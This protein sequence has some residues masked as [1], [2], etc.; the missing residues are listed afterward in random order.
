MPD[1]HQ[2]TLD[3][4]YLQ[5]EGTILLSGIQAL[6]RIP[7]DQHRADKRNGLDTATFISGYRGSPLGGLDITLERSSRVLEE[8]QVV[9]VPGVNE[10]LGATAVFGSQ[11][12]NLLPK[13]KHDGVLGMWYGKGPG[14]D[15]SGDAFRHANFTG[16]GHYGGVLALAGDD[17]VAKSSTIPSQSEVGLYDLHMPTLYPGSIQE[18]LD[19]GR[20]GFELSRYCGS[21]VGFKIV[22]DVADAFG[23]VQVGIN[24][25]QIKD[26]GF[27]V[28][29]QPWQHTQNPNLLAPYSLYQEREMVEGRLEAA[30]LF[31]KANNLNQITVPTRAARLGIVS[32]GKTYYDLREALRSLGLNDEALRAHGIRILKIGM[33]HPLEPTIVEKFARD[34]EE[35]LVVE[36]KRSFLEMF[37]RDK[38]YHLRDR[39]RV[40]GKRDNVGRPLVPGYAELDADIIAENI[41]KF[42][43]NWT[44]AE[45]IQT[46][47]QVLHAPA[48]SLDIA[49]AARTPYFC[50]G[51]P[52]NRST[53]VPEGSFAGGGIGCH[54]MAILMDRDI[55]GLTQMGGEGAQWVGAAEFVEVTHIFQ[56]IGDGTLFHSGSLAIRQSVS[57]GVN[58][59]Y[60]ILYNSAVAMTG[61]QVVDGAI[62]VPQLTRELA[63]EGVRRTIVLSDEPHKYAP[64]ARWAEDVDVWDRGRLDE[65]QRILR[66]VSGVTALIYDQTCAAELRRQRKRGLAPEPRMSVFI[67][68]AVCEGCGD[69]GFKSNCLSVF[70]VETEFGRKTQIHQSSCNKDFTCLEGDCPAFI[71]VYPDEKNTPKRDHVSYTVERDLP[72]PE[73]K[74]GSEANIFMMG[75]GGTGVVT[76][77]QILATAALLDGLHISNLDQT[78]LSQKGGPVISHLKLSKKQIEV[79]NKIGAGQADAYIVFDML[80]GASENNLRHAQPGRTYAVVSSSKIPTGAMVNSTAVEF[81]DADPLVSRIEAQTRP[82]DNVYLDAVA[83]AE[84][85]FGS[86]MPANIIAIGAAYQAGLIPIKSDSIEQAIRLNG[87][88]AEANINAFRVGRLTVAEP[89]WAASLELS[90]PGAMQMNGTHPSVQA[91]MLLKTVQTNGTLKKLLENRVPELIDFQNE[92]YAR[93]YV[94]FVA[95]V[96]IAEGKVNGTTKLSE[97]VARNLFKLM[98]YK[99]EYEV[100]RLHLKP[101]LNAALE[102]QFGAGARIAYQLHPPLLRYIG[103]HRKLSFGRWFEPTLQLLRGLRRLRGTPLD[104]FGYTKIRRTERALIDEYRTLIEDSLSKLSTDTHNQA[105]ELA[106]LPDMIRGYEEIK[107]DNVARFRARVQELTS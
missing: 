105:V 100:A 99:D 48:A 40:I 91:Q 25:I 59:T 18:V 2:F 82:E 17:P 46:R 62:P 79:S 84:Q 97:T 73:R 55:V 101:E 71:I 65:A 92:K 103:L 31:A 106:G 14:V 90:R 70:P 49:M 12:A 74:I 43:A 20:L 19:Y 38:L 29:G 51:C 35:I 28:G 88:A 66:D 5:E 41:G 81:P 23:T 47:L 102:K 3:S 75:I 36:E 60:K 98:A 83:M 10:D 78:G 53:V 1:N 104:L 96:Q 95:R 69:C 39:P 6:V 80:T 30:R 37:L 94:D 13:P 52:H 9:F 7:L 58:L 76:L 72:E 56:N 54:T 57:A 15:R 4:K 87:V 33:L 77:N 42:L 32:S 68:E 93:K 22:T 64:Y 61:G 50:S 34:L 67:N 26:P 24:R 21:W 86:H 11:I 107:M 16:V 27:K 85:L 63:A 45:S 8:H 89:Q 44:D